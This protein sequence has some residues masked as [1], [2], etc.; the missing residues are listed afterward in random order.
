MSVSK[1]AAA[2]G[3]VLNLLGAAA[4]TGAMA[5]DA[6]ASPPKVGIHLDFGIQAPESDYPAFRALSVPYR[7]LDINRASLAT[8]ETKEKDA[9]P[10]VRAQDHAFVVEMTKILNQYGDVF[11]DTEMRGAFFK[12]SHPEVLRLKTLCA[13]P[14]VQRLQTRQIASMLRGDDPA[15][16]QAMLKAD[17]DFAAMSVADQRLLLRFVFAL[18]KSSQAMAPLQKQ[19]V[20]VYTARMRGQPEP[21]VTQP[22]ATANQP[23]DPPLT[24]DEALYLNG[25]GWQIPWDTAHELAEVGTGDIVL[26]CG[27]KADGHLSDCDAVRNT[28]SGAGSDALIA[29]F[30]A[31]VH[32]DAD[33][34]AAGIPAG[35]RTRFTA[36]ITLPPTS[37]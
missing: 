35:A 12:F 30:T 15:D 24:H 21:A 37:L 13:S 27:I 9:T 17:P 5:A 31:G 3:L 8:V 1:T 20:A 2:M 4:A 16:Y 26:D 23:P 14:A 28:L 19:F 29:S 18:Q 11:V 25:V 32:T 10:E 34:V 36:H 6:P 22:E 33:T 7:L